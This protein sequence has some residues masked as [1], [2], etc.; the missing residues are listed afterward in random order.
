MDAAWRMGWQDWC[1]VGERRN[2]RRG[3]YDGVGFGEFDYLKVSLSISG[4]RRRRAL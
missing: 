2:F 3:G 4:A 1:Q